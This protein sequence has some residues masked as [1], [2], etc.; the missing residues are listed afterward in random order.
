MVRWMS[1]ATLTNTCGF[2]TKIKKTVWVG[3]P[4]VYT[5]K[6]DNDIPTTTI[7]FVA[8][9]VYHTAYL[10]LGNAIKAQISGYVS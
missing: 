6:Y 4:D 1:I 8:P 3:R 5:I 7:N 9:N 10:D 2:S